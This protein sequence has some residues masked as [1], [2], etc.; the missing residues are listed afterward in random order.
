M[1]GREIILEIEGMHCS[2]CANT[3]EK[4]LSKLKGVT[5]VSVSFATK[6]AIVLYNPDKI[7]EE[8]IGKVIEKLGYTPIFP[9]KEETLEEREKLEVKNQLLIFFVGLIFTLPVFVIE[10]LYYSPEKKLS[11]ISFSYTRPNFSWL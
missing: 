11:A 6:K 8:K 3:I 10:T 9:E 4:E 2:T 7:N 1:K 5:K